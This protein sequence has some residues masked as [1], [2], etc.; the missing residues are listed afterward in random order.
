MSMNPPQLT[1]QIESNYVNVNLSGWQEFHAANW[2]KI[3][4]D[5]QRLGVSLH[6]ESYIWAVFLRAYNL[7]GQNISSVR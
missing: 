7:T 3:D 1:G 2:S 4:G 6:M 5:L